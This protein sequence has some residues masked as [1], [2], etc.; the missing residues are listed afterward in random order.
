ML[1]KQGRRGCYARGR[2]TP[3]PTSAASLRSSCEL[4]ETWH[5]RALDSDPLLFPH[6][7]AHPDDREVAAFL[8]ASLA[9][10][11]VASVKA[12]VEAVLAALGPL[13]GSRP[14]S[15][16]CGT[17]R[18]S[19]AS[20]TGGSTAEPSGRSSTASGRPFGT[21]APSTRSSSPTTRGAPTTF[22]RLDRFFSVLRE[23][24]GVPAGAVP[25]GLRFL[26]PS[27]AEG[28]ACKR[29][30][31]FL[32]WTVRDDGWDLGLFARAG[33]NPAR[34][35]L[36]LDTH[37]HRIARYLGLTR[38]PDGRPRRGP[39]GDGVAGED[40]PAGPRPFDWALSAPRDPRGVR[41][42]PARDAAATV[43]RAPRVPRR[44]AAHRPPFPEDRVMLK[45]SQLVVLVLCAA[46]VAFLGVRFRGTLSQAPR[47]RS[48]AAA[49]PPRLVELR[50]GRTLDLAQPPGRLLV[51]HFW[52]TWCAPCVEEFPG[53]LAWW[54]EVK[55]DPRIEVLAVSVDADWKTA[56]SW[57]AKQNATDLPMALDP[58]GRQ[59]SPSGPRSSPRR[60]SWLPTGRSSST[61]PGPS[62]G[63]LQG[64]ASSST[65]SGPVP[66]R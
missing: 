66:A 52:A 64:H 31:L 11:R 49:P 22:R 44:P 34:L 35:L 53:L 19:T 26:L 61:R 14:A 12:S 63:R 23:R 18:A 8:A 24:T 9:F 7:Y 65:R 20:S 4:E 30:H 38:R 6:R 25:R 45:R 59:R 17:S 56:E 39:R 51:L 60:G 41:A 42:R 40:R 29:A 58:T 2:C 57:L 47:R 48:V 28:G 33:F 1:P 32:R 15:D 13:P 55:D 16:A 21:R 3:G 10:G 62:T 27:P 43:P 5:D 50:G 46:A 36:P 37:V 54:R